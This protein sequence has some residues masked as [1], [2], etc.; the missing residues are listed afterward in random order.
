MGL[1]LE[2][3]GMRTCVICD[4]GANDEHARKGK[5]WTVPGISGSV[6]V[7][8]RCESIL[9]VVFSEPWRREKRDKAAPGFGEWLA[10]LKNAWDSASQCFRCQ[11]SGARLHIA[12]DDEGCSSAPDWDHDEN[13]QYIVVAAGLPTAHPDTT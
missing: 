8:G 5:R 2:L 4:F 6:Y 3:C 13:G 10:V 7:C 9:L 11:I 12:I 1:R